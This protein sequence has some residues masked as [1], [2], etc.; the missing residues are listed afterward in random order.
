MPNITAKY[1]LDFWFS[2]RV[3]PLHF[4]KDV[5]FDR[6]VYDTFF[7]TY[8]KA[9]QGKLNN[10]RETALESLALIIL[11]DQFPRNMFR[12]SSRSFATDCQ[13]REIARY[14]IDKGFDAELTQEQCRF[15]YMPFMHSEDLVDQEFSVTQYAKLGVESNLK[16]AIVHRNIIR[17]FNRFPHRNNVL[18]RDSTP[19]EI[20][21]LTEPNSSF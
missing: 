12:N 20:K 3:K 6:E 13:A 16:F 14:A 5:V 17:H 2:D 4:Q 11:L 9:S 10:W 1:I 7:P 21:F 8:E 19:E 15:L 18:G